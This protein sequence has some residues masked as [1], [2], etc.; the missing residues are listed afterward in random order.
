MGVGTTD[1]V[2]TARSNTNGDLLSPTAGTVSLKATGTNNTY[3]I[4]ERFVQ[5]FKGGELTTDKRFTQ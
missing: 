2:F 1:Y 3:K 5:D 4:T